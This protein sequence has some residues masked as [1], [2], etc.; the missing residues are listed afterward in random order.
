MRRTLLLSLLTIGLSSSA[1]AAGPV[2]FGL[3]GNAAFLNVPEPLKEAYGFG[4]GGGAHLDISLLVLSI[5]VSGDYISFPIDEGK[6]KA[7]LAA[8]GL[9]ASD[10]QFDGGRIGILSFA[11]NG[12]M[13]FPV[14]VFSPYITAGAGLASISVS[15]LSIRYQGQPVV[16]AAGQ[17]AETKF[18]INVGVGAD[19]DI[20]VA[21]LFIEAK[22]T[23]IFTEGESSSYVPVTLGITF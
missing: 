12:K 11:V 13:G 21:T 18:S 2:R 14:P 3:H 1:F 10:F 7:I 19:L 5:R 4:Y 15:D 9:N 22:Y 16:S 23:L 17:K 8:G 6:F 20:I